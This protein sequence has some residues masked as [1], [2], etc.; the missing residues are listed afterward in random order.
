MT[1]YV[2]NLTWLEQFYIITYSKVSLLLII[3]YLIYLTFL[4]NFLNQ[5]FKS[6]FKSTYAIKL[7]NQ[8]GDAINL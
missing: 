2:M 7:L 8:I 1:N 6:T 4:I 3:R 5:L